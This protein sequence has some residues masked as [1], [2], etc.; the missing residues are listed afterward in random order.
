MD[1]NEFHERLDAFYA[2]G[3][4]A[5]A[6]AFLR[7][8]RGAALER[9]D[10]MA[11]LTADNAL[12]GHC[13][14][15]VIFDEVE[16]Y[17]QEAK[18]C[19]E[20]LGLHGTHAEATTFLNTATAMCIM[21]RAEESEA[22]YDAAEAIY[23]EI[24]PPNDPY[25]AAVS[26]NRGLL[27]RAQGNAAAAYASFQK[28]LAVLHACP[29]TEAETAATLLNLASVSPDTQTAEA[30]LAAARPYFASEDG[31]HDIHRFTAMAASAELAYRRGDFAAAGKGFEETA[32]QWARAA[33]APQRRIV[34]LRNAL[35]SYEKAGDAACADRIRAMLEEAK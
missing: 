13:R 10:R 11:L 27:L 32:E 9:G 31:Q 2:A 30:H 22:L 33:L 29:D 12:I 17:Y 7:A 21:G 28:A 6:Y 16:G 24:L 35:A 25:M 8:Q 5:G 15:N 3:D 26:N 20:R 18:D 23:R 14:E 34:L 19:I 1:G 4:V